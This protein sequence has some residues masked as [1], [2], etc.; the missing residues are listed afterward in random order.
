MKNIEKE[1]KFLVK[2]SSYK[3][4]ET[5]N[6]RMIQ[7]YICREPGRTVRVRIAGDK[8]W[9]TIKGPGSDT[10]ISRFEWEKEIPADEASDLLGLCPPDAHIIDKTRHFVPVGN[11]IFEVDE[12]H[13]EN[14]GLTVAEIELDDENEEF[15][16]PDWLGTEVT[17]D[18]RYYNSMLTANPYSVWKD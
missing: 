15:P 12:F 2:D 7:G 16:R 1:R 13:G 17:G 3:A 8:A 5:G 10:G 11:R 18:R 14:Q 6:V 9:I 4:S